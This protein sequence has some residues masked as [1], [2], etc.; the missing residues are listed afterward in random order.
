[1]NSLARWFALG[2]MAI[3]GWAASPAPVAAQEPLRLRISGE[4]PM[5][6]LDLQMAQRFIE[7][8]QEE[9]GDDFEHE[10]FHTEALGDEVVHMQMIRTGQIDVYPMGSDAIQL[11]PAWAIFDLPFVFKDRDTV[12]H[13]LDGEV[14]QT[15]RESMR[16]AAN[17]EVLAFGEIGF[18]QITN[19]VRPIVEPADLEGLRLRVP[20]SRMRTL[21]FETYGATPVTMNLGELYLALQ[22]GTV[23][24]QENPLAGTVNRSFHEVQRY[25]SMSNHVYTP[26][27]FVMNGDKF[28]SL[29]AEHQE[30]GQ[31]GGAGSGA[32]YPRARRQGRRRVPG[33][34]A[35]ERRQRGQRDRSC[36]LPG[37]FGAG[38]CGDRRVRR[39]GIDAT[40]SRGGARRIGGSASRP[41]GARPAPSLKREASMASVTTERAKADEQEAALAAQ[42]EQATRDL[43][44]ADPDAG[45]SRF[46]RIVNRT[47]ELFGVLLL[48][49]LTG[50]VFLNATTRYLF[51]YSFIWGDEL[52]IA[53]IPWVAMAGLFLAVR[54]RNVIRIDFFVDKFWPRPR[55]VLR[56]A[57]ELLSAIVFVYLAWVSVEY[58]HRFGGD[59]LIYLRWPRGLFSASF[60]I[61]PLLAAFA[62]LVTF[63]REA[64][65]GPK[66]PPAEGI[67]PYDR[68]PDLDPASPG[69][70]GLRRADAGRAA[71][72]RGPEFLP[73]RPMAADPAADHDLGRELLHADRPAAVRARGHDH[74]RGRHIGAA[75][76]VRAG[77]RR[78]DAGRP[79]PGRRADQHLLRR[80]DRLV[81][82]GPRRHRLDHHS[83]A[84]ARRLPRRGRGFGHGLV[85]GHRPADPAELADDPL[86]GDHRRVARLAVP[87]RPGSRHPPRAGP[88]GR[89]RGARP[90]PRLAA[91]RPSLAARDLEDRASLGAVLRHAR[92][93]SS[94]ASCS[95]CSRRPKVPR[96]ASS[97]PSFLSCFVYRTLRPADLLR[98]FGNAVQLTGE[99]LVIVALSFALGAGLTAAHA[100]QALAEIVS[101]IVGENSQFLQLS[102]LVILGIIAGMFLDP[103]IPVLVPVILPLLTLYE[104]DL[105]HFG[106]LMVMCVVIGQLTPP[107]AIALIITSRIADCDQMKIFVANMPFLLAI[108]AF[109]IV[110]MLVPELSTWL[111]SIARS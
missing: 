95:A 17:L 56:L 102:A 110:M 75:V 4:N 67:P 13:L 51:K 72:G 36:C 26:V 19:A 78:L 37:R 69:A 70:S 7:I 21:M 15:L 106:A 44:L 98:V 10:F 108:V 9:L 46:D 88:D 42:V 81:D 33:H 16:D 71:G 85:L 11:D 64:R 94:A 20:G 3:V 109:L 76:R 83:G 14:G 6:G 28:D 87:R 35:G 23:D 93:S 100:P 22:Q 111:P 82:G 61:G 80:H 103:L 104:I 57:G 59:Q 30:A 86:L 99:L 29:S 47:A 68:R 89:R 5:S 66:L 90:S 43:E 18:R 101:A 45:A 27:T 97:T 48:G 62:Y 60:V 107:L 34:A 84:Q 2:L 96:S 25:F 74:E 77:A 38:L 63:W 92:C 55:K 52:I 105:I 31:A 1:M 40:G 91:P 24:G 73:E 41:G 53:I 39:R 32:L 58:V 50:L 49:L 12:A 65:G 79:R 8:L 54:R